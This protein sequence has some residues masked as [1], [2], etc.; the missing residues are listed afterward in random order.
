MK[1][2]A[3]GAVLV[4]VLGAAPA[5]AQ[6][7]AWAGYLDYAYVYTSAESDALQA[8][9][10]EYAGEAGT[11]LERYVAERFEAVPETGGP[12]DEARLRRQAVAHLLDYLARGEPDSLEK[13]VDAVRR[14][15]DRLG[16]HENRY[17]YHYVLAHR[18]LEKGRHFD[19]VGEVLDL[20]REV[21]VPLEGP[22]ET[23]Q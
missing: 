11:S 20:W 23:L 15:E 21:V 10:N 3:I 14:L 22:Y 6:E 7:D 16:R 9:L 4:A 1:Q 13:S 2:G 8:R 17:W 19:F 5:A 12:A 18:A